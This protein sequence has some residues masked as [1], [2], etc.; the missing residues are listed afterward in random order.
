MSDEEA[1][2]EASILL[3]KSHFQF[4]FMP[5]E[6]PGS[7]AGPDGDPISSAMA[8][9]EPPI[10]PRRLIKAVASNGFLAA[11]CHAV[12]DGCAGVR[13]DI[14]PR[15][16]ESLMD[17]DFDLGDRRTWPESIVEQRQML[18]VFIQAGFVG[19]GAKS[20]RMGFKDQEHD[21]VILGWGGVGVLRTEF[22]DKKGMPPTPKGFT[23]IEACNAR[24]TRPSRTVTMVPVPVALEDGS[25]F[26]VEE[27][28]F[29]RRIRVRMDN[30]RYKWFKEFGD[31]R[32]MSSKTGKYSKG[33]RR[34]PPTRVGQPGT[35]IPGKLKGKDTPAME[36]MHWCTHF[37]GAKPY[38]LSG[39]HSELTSA[40]S[41]KEQSGLILEYLK[42]GLHNVILAAGNRPFEEA[43][44]EAAINKIDELGR[45]RKGLGSLITMAL[46]PADS[47]VQ[48]SGGNIFGSDSTSDRG[49]II[50]HELTTKLQPE[51][52]NSD[53]LTESLAN[54]FSNSERIPSLLLGRSDSYNFATASAA[55]TV[56]NR[57]RFGPHHEEREAFLDKILIE[58]G[59]TM[60]KVKV[61]SPEWDEKEPMSGMMSVGGQLGGVSVNKAIEIMSGMTNIEMKPVDQWWG[62]YPMPIVRSIL[63]SED[64]V[65]TASVL[66]IQI[67][68]SDI[69]EPVT[70]AVVETLNDMESRIVNGLKE[71]GV[72]E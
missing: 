18:Q 61:V 56:V 47:S 34:V 24:F 40:D 66:G 20:L 14:E 53:G 37:P 3:D 26:W 9:V 1:R 72:V 63:D 13:Y 52:L 8:V 55:W 38:G 45:G 36:I 11:V 12:A 30:G 51:L 5:G 50:L 32:S 10:E 19:S 28:R 69:K 58:M 22:V 6:L 25:V 71:R 2:S 60:W 59:I 67:D 41:W 4:S 49:R 29:F 42:S 23:N 44:V 7:E 21:R 46:V 39:W 62:R 64:P 65:S 15:F 35:Y 17:S 43:T 16:N 57:L 33:S 31:W 48:S 54:R 70:A 68:E 27:P